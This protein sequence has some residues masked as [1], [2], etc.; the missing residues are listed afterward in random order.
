[1]AGSKSAEAARDFI[2][3]LTT[4]AAKKLFEAAGVD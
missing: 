4:P 3:Y 1:M 2:R